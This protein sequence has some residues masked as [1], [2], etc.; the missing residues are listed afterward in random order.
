MRVECT[1]DLVCLQELARERGDS[2]ISHSAYEIIKRNRVWTAIRKGSH[3]A[4]DEQMD[5]SRGANDNAIATDI[6]R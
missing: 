5:L 6:R 3:L 2:G 4:V 1:A